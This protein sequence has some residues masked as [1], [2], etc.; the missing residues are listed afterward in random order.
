MAPQSKKNIVV[1]GGSYVGTRAADLIAQRLHDTHRTILIEQ[2]S[3]FHNLFDFPRYAVVPGLEHQAFIPYTTMFTHHPPGSTEVL[4]ARVTEVHPNHV[5]LDKGDP[6]P[7]EYLVI[8]TGMHLSPPGT[9]PAQDKAGGVAYLQGHQ[10]AV[11]SAQRIVIVGGGANGVQ[12]A[13]DIKDYYPTKSVTLIHSRLHLMNTFR[14]ELHDVIMKRANELGIDIFLGER[15][16]VPKGGFPLS[17]SEIDVGLSKGRKLRADLVILATGQTPLS[18]PIRSLSPGSIAP[19][20]LIS[21][22]PTLQLADAEFPHIFAVGDVA[23]TREQKSARYG[24][25]HALVVADNIARLA[26][27][28]GEPLSAF[29]PM[30]KGIHMTLGMTCHVLFQESE[31]SNGEPS[32]RLHSDGSAGGSSLRFWESKAPGLTNYYL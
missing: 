28:A 27:G 31:D 32:V 29:S 26:A 21:V 23:D 15:V 16:D 18:G 6:V 25:M 1:V 12:L 11:A 7:Y 17:S 9:M 2:H 13:T 24:A 14:P 19:D 20:G 8:A 3:H 4:Q 22:L 10:R 5:E 30:P